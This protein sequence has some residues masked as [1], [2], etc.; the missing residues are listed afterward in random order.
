MEWFN[1]QK[2]P[3][4]HFHEVLVSDGLGSYAVAWYKP[5]AKTWH[6]SDDLLYAEN[7]DGR[8]H[9]SIEACDI[10]IWSEINGSE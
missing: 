10:K 9:I 5:G 2:T 1:A 6:A 8:C 7:Y 4:E 3:P